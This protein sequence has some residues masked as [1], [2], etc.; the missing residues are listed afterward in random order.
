[1]ITPVPILQDENEFERMLAI[2]EPRYPYKILEVGSMYGGTLYHWTYIIQADGQLVSVDLI[3]SPSDPRYA[4]VIE[5]KKLWQDWADMFPKLILLKLLKWAVV[6]VLAGGITG[7][8]TSSVY[9][10]LSRNHYQPSRV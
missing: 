8:V 6:A 9:S 3:I 4:Q 5:S 7:L 10:S 2:V 1:M